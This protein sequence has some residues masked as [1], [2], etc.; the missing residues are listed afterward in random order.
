MLPLV[1]SMRREHAAAPTALGPTARPWL[2]GLPLSVLVASM[3]ASRVDLLAGNGPLVLTP[4]LVVAPVLLLLETRAVLRR[5][6]GLPLC[7]GLAPLLRL[8]ATLMSVV[9]V[10]VLRSV[11]PEVSVRRFALLLAHVTAAWLL[12]VLVHIQPN[13]RA[14]LARAGGIGVALWVAFALLQA[15]TWFVVGPDA[16]WL[17]VLSLELSTYA[18]V[19]PRLSGPSHDPNLGGMLLV[20]F[21]FLL[22]RHAE[23]AGRAVRWRGWLLPVLGVLL[24]LTLSRSALLAAIVVAVAWGVTAQGAVIRR[25]LAGW[26]LGVMGSLLAVGLL[27]TVLRPAVLDVASAALVVA[28]ERFELLEGSGGERLSLI[29]RGVDVATEGPESLLLGTGYG[30]AHLFLNDIFFEN[31]YGNYHSLLITLVAE[32]GVPALLLTLWLFGGALRTATAERPLVVALLVFSVV[33]QP[34]TDPWF[35]FVLSLAWLAGSSALPRPRLGRAPATVPPRPA[36]VM[37]QVVTLCGVA[38]GLA[39]SPLG[40]QEAVAGGAMAGGALERYL[41]A[42]EVAG[43]VTPHPT[44]GVRGLTERELRRMLAGAR[45]HPWQRRAALE[46]TLPA[47]G[48]AARVLP[49]TTRAAFNSAFPFDGEAGGHDGPVWAGRGVTSALQAGAVVR[50]GPLTVQL[51]PT[52]FRAENRPFD[53]A[54]TGVPGEGMYRNELTPNNTDQPQRFG[55]APYARLDAGQSFARLDVWRF[56]AGVSS[57][58]QLWGGG[59][60]VPLMFGPSGGGLPHVFLGTERPLSLGVAGVQWRLMAGRPSHSAWSPETRERLLTGGVVV[61]TPH[62]LPGL[63]L[64]F[65]RTSHDRWPE[66]LTLRALAKPLSTNISAGEGDSGADGNQQATAFFRWA[67]RGSGLEVWGEFLRIDGAANLRTLLVEPDDLAGRALGIRRVWASPDGARLTVLRAEGYRTVSGHR[68]RGGARLGLAFRGYNPEQHSG[69]RQGHTHRGQ[70]LGSPGVHGGMGHIVGVDRF[71]AGGAWTVEWE[72]RLVRD[73]NTVVG[74]LMPAPDVRMEVQHATGLSYTHFGSRV[75][76]SGGARLVL[77]VHRHLS[78]R[79]EPN[80]NLH[81]GLRVRL[82]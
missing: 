39:A 32:A 53:L 3:G 78:A 72:Q 61:L 77:H 25:R 36:P 1:T 69:I 52:V 24:S 68:E 13:R 14:L 8:L 30:T 18:G 55:K 51:A 59:D 17:G 19:V 66:R 29:G 20:F 48:V 21:A 33:Q 81:A 43:L 79:T 63:E 42:A 7:A 11:D 76:L 71:F 10:S 82:P 57:A 56:T 74:D 16:G 40:A 31:E 70:S 37:P 27:L 50:V 65:G 46:D 45:A 23:P 62:V 73:R 80:L 6:G 58:A 75:D 44:W 4:F 54:P 35:W 28:G 34:H 15:G 26:A 12:A 2:A 38:V 41:R 60:R 22:W 5:A 67:P 47:W 49:M 9:L 64:G